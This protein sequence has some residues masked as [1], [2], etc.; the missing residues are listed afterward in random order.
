MEMKTVSMNSQLLSPKVFKELCSLVENTTGIR[1]QSG[2]EEFVKCRLRKRL[3]VLGLENFDQY[4]ELVRNDFSGQEFSLMI[5]AVTTNKT[6]FFRQIE[7]FNYLYSIF[8][9]IDDQDSIRIWSAGCSTGEEPF[10]I[11]MV[12]QEAI[13]NISARDVRI[14]ATDIS[15]DVLL[16]AQKGIYEETLLADVPLPLQKKYFVSLGKTTPQRYQVNKQTKSL[17]YLARLNLMSQWPMK[18]QFDAIFCRNVMIYFDKK[19]QEQ[20]I[21]RFWDLLKPDG[22]LFIGHS[23]SLPVDNGFEYVQ[24]AIYRKPM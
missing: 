14:L 24:P 11:A 21:D 10:S 17:I 23:E 2:K 8:S 22:H 7:H 1:I 20:L 9:N 12:L 3:D 16:T 5:N 13:P 4:L 6:F 18:N 15:N 19:V